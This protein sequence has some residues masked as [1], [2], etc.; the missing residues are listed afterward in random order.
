MKTASQVVQSRLA[1]LFRRL[2]QL[3]GFHIA[4]DLSVTDVEFERCPGFTPGR[5]LYEEIAA[6][7]AE[8]L[9]DGE[10]ALELL[11]NRTFARTL[12]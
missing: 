12:H 8:A 1:K 11:R 9:E 7:L 5:K 2:P 4:G 10:D 3:A 6:V